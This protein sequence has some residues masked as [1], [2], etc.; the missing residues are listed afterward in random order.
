MHKDRQ[1]IGFHFTQTPNSR[2]LSKKLYT[3]KTI[4]VKLHTIFVSKI[5]H[6]DVCNFTH[7]WCVNLLKNVKRIY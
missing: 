3:L 4:V 7:L 2:L 6:L 5:T 1:S